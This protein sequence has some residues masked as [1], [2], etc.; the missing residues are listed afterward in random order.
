M[1]RYIA[2]ATTLTLGISTGVSAAHAAPITTLEQCYTAVINWCNETFP[3]HADQCGSSSGLNDCDEE[4]GN[5]TAATPARAYLRNG[6]A[7][8]PRTFERLLAGARTMRV[9]R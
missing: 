6:P 1:I 7:V 3:D 4:F 5:Q 9:T 2:I 8:P